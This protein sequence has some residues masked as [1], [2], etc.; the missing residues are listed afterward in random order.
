M[1]YEFTRIA[2]SRN[3][4]QSQQILM[5]ELIE[6]CQKLFN[7]CPLPMWDQLYMLEVISYG[8]LQQKYKGVIR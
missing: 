5:E 8:E 6:A 1:M 2:Y 3:I 4:T 7:R